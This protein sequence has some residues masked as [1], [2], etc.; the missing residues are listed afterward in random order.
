MQ[1]TIR[2]GEVHDQEETLRARDRGAAR[3]SLGYS[4]DLLAL[5]AVLATAAVEQLD[6][7]P[8]WLLV[9]SGSGNAKTETVANL[10]GAGATV[11][12]TITSERR[13]P[14]GDHAQGTQRQRDRRATPQTR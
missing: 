7:D 5:D 14:I 13:A 12:R 1:Y 10:A 9:I 2:L 4:Y 3:S 11:T 8:V 6:G